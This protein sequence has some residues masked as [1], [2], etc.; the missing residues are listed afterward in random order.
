MDIFQPSFL[1]M[2][3]PGS[4]RKT[5]LCLLNG[6]TST[7]SLSLGSRIKGLLSFLVKQK[8]TLSLHAHLL[9]FQNHFFGSKSAVNDTAAHIH[10]CPVLEKKCGQK[11]PE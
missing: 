3:V 6:N 11:A 4:D 2:D 7:L 10:P 8:N 1:L 9:G 5:L